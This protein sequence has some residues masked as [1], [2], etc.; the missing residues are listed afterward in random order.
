MNGKKSDNFVIHGDICYS[1]DQ[2]TLRCVEGGYLVCKDG[3]SQGV[4]PSLPDWYMNLPLLDHSDR[5]ILPGLVDLHMHAP[6][7]AFRGLGMD[8]ELLE[9]LEA[10]TFPEE[11]K[12]RNLGYAR[13]AYAAVARDLV[14]GPNTRVCMYATVHLPATRLLMDMMETTGLVCM[15]GKVNM[16]RNNPPYLCESSAALSA[17]HT[18]M[19]LAASAGR[20]KNVSAILTPRF[21][22]VCSDELMG[23][24]QKLQKEFNVPLQSHL[25]ESRAEVEWVR[26][27]CPNSKNYADAY[28]SFG[29]FGGDVPTIMA[30]CVW[31]EEDEI[32]LIRE[33][34]VYIAHCP[35]SN[36]NLTSGV[37]PV[38]RLL[39][40]DVQIGLG[41]DVAG[42]CHTSIFRAMADAI[43]TSK[44]RH[45]LVDRSE[46]PLSIAEAF[47]LG[48]LGGGSF[49]GNVGSFAAGYEFDAIIIDDTSIYAPFPLT[50]EERLARV[51][52]FSDD[53]H[54]QEK[55]VR[56]KC[57]KC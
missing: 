24:L 10:Y 48:T 26:K 53:R 13:N 49:F 33:K 6:Q 56:G 17:E 7:F 25:C 27:L 12:Y 52:H 1:L 34:N 22:P 19:W 9:W 50:V 35:Q 20:Y 32:A 44:L 3:K 36:A 31:P 54:I 8:L 2:N 15:V 21:I 47:Y 18:H 4:Y 28:D 46:A 38:R 30:H 5:L 45:L 39:N 16:D 29:L 42:G 43:Q 57:V 40:N 37:A 14:N 55:Y 41:S 23:M 11:S 51:M